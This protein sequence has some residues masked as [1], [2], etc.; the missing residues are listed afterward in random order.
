MTQL[1]IFALVIF[2][3][4]TTGVL[5]SSPKSLGVFGKWSTWSYTDNS[6]NH[7]FIYSSPISKEPASL[8]HGDVSFFI[9]AA[10]QTEARSEASLQTGYG[11]AGNA[12]IVVNVGAQ[13][14]HMISSGNG[15]WLRRTGTRE[16]EFLTALKQERTMTVDAVSGRGNKTHYVFSLD[17]VTKAMARLRQACP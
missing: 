16:M 13:P 15:A 9:R 8:N 1:S 4:S 14:F 11:L 6:G 5:A 17:G 7:C 3:L 10:R 12:D 2:V